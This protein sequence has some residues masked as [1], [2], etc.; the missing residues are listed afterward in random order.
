MAIRDQSHERFISI[1]YKLLS[2]TAALATKSKKRAIA[3]PARLKD[4][5]RT[6]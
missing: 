6:T 2:L 3:W 4:T 1:G 5:K